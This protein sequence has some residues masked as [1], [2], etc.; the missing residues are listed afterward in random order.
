MAARREWERAHWLWLAALAGGTSY[1]FAVVLRWDGAAVHIWK[2]SGV[3][4]LAAWAVVNARTL[5]GR[6][7]AAVMACGALGDWL[8]DAVGMLQGA[9]AFAVGHAVAIILYLR[10]RR[11][12]LSASQ[13]A[14][15]WLTVPL[16]LI[17]V[18]A[19]SRGAAPDLAMAAIGYTAIVAAMAAAAWTSRFPRYRT[20][21]GAMLFLAS[22]LFIFASEG[23][24][25]SK[26]VTLWLVWPLYFG[27]Q[28]LIARGVV[29]TLAREADAPSK[30]TAGAG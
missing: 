21:I 17:I 13:R 3:A 16:A 15:G 4:L 2:A 26:D 30:G 28:A 27:G 14:L 6:M 18:W 24:T 9:A 1:F 25:L 10:H 23:G 19:L 29:S 11:A 8:L 20:G 22:D 7:I 5:D 12:R